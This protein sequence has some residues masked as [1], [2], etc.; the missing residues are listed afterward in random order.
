MRETNVK[1]T[2]LCLIKFLRRPD[3]QR[4]LSM[5]LSYV[6]VYLLLVKKYAQSISQVLIPA[7]FESYDCN[8]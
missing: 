4:D 6:K 1:S 2:M 3:E 8:M 7:T 5:K